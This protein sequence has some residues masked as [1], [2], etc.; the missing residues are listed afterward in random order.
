MRIRKFDLYKYIINDRML[1]EAH[2]QHLS[3][4]GYDLVYL[5]LKGLTSL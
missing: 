2:K 4:F 3:D 5:Y 1:S